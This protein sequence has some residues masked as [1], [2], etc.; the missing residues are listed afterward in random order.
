MD[1]NNNV[2]TAPAL[3][4]GEVLGYLKTGRKLARLGWNGQGQ[5]IALQTPD[6]NSKMTLPYIY[7]FTK[8]AKLVPWVA[9]Q[10][11]LFAD[12]WFIIPPAGDQPS[13]QDTTQSTGTPT[14]PQA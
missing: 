8:Q 13:S 2:S 9:S 11:D 10:S 14:D 3:S 7:I 1:T 5:Y 4:F 12:D 6:E